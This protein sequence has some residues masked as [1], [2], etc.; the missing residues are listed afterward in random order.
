MGIAG[1]LHVLKIGRK[2]NEGTFKLQS[3]KTKESVHSF[4]SSFLKLCLPYILIQS[5]IN[6]MWSPD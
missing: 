5:D 1:Q 4:N 3:Q 6:R 2:V